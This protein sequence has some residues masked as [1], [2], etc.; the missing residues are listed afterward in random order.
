MKYFRIYKTFFKFNLSELSAY[1][2]NLINSVFSSLLWGGFSIVLVILLTTRTKEVFGWS[3]EEI[4]LLFGVYN[5]F[6]STFHFLFSRSFE[7]FAEII[8]LGKLDSV[9]IKPADSQFMMSFTYV[10]ITSLLR[11]VLGVAFTAYVLNMMHV[12]PSLFEIFFTIVIMGFS[13]MVLYSIWYIAATCL[14]WWSNLSN[15]VGV[16]F[17]VN[18]SF[19]YP[20]QMFSAVS[21]VLL[22]AVFPLTL[23]ATVP[24]QFLIG[25]ASLGNIFWLAFFA[26]TFLA[27]SRVFWKFALRFYTSV[28]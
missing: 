22:Y 19:R 12:V 4:F 16:M 1:R 20:Q 13:I 10:N 7:H 24:T 28:G 15:L 23:V 14:I 11:V 5:I 26:F 3:R 17:Q 27:I 21:P 2:G 9:L 8:H 18:A 25:N 6:T